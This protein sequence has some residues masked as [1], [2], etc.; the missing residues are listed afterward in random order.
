MKLEEIKGIGEN[1]LKL[2]NKLNIKTPEQLI[3]YYPYKYNII[4]NNQIN[5]L[6][7]KIDV[8]I[9]GIIITEPKTKKLNEKRNIMFFKIK[10]DNKI[11][12][13]IIF[14]RS[15]YKNKLNIGKTIIIIGKF[16]EKSNKIIAK[17]IRFE[18]FK[19]SE[20]IEPIYHTT[21]GI[22]GNQINKIVCNY[23]SEKKHIKDYIPEY[24][25]KKYNF[26][27]K[28]ESIVNI[29]NP[30]NIDTL[31]KAI[32]R[33]KYEELFIFLLKLSYL[34]TKNKI[35]GIK[36]QINYE[37]VR[38]F[39][40]NLPFTLTKDQV[41]CIIEIYND[42]IDEKQMNRLLQGD[43]GSGK[44][45]VAFT[46]LYMNY[47]SGYQGCLMAPTELLAQQH[48]NNI[49]K[50][51]EK[52]IN[53]ELLT[54]KTKLK[55]KKMIKQK[56]KDNKIDIIIGTH[57]LISEDVIFNNLGLVITDEQ[58]RFGVKQRSNLKN[59][60]KTPDILYMSATPIPRTYALT[61]Y[62]DMEISNIK[63]KPKGRKEV[64]TLL[65]KTNEI[66]DV[67]ELMNNELN[68]NHQIYVV[69]PL[70]EDNEYS[71]LQNIYSLAKKIE[72]LFKGKYKVGILHGKMKNEEKDNIM[73]NFEKNILKILV[74]TTV[75]EVGID[76]E[77][78]T[79]IV[80][81]DS[82][83]FGLSELHQL[84]GRVGR[85]EK[86]SYCVL[87]SD[88]ETERLK[89]LTNESDGFKIS[90]EDFKLRGSGDIFGIRQSGEINFVLTNIK[91]EYQ[92]LKK[93]KIDS[94]IFMK[95]YINNYKYKHIKEILINS[96][97]L[98]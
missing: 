28:E 39:I 56:L 79:M 12:N 84:R 35:K 10:L 71:N 41:K 94:D 57:A 27:S 60:G 67:I 9:E 1:K 45:I 80:I 50:I 21:K 24:L 8:V 23:L 22:T 59:K 97:N 49:K 37:I 66:K 65:K 78:A 29:H 54:G 2:L 92:L 93:I 95:K 69:A 86:E 87:I 44:T 81:F 62:G 46:A 30:K 26:I 25:V 11:I 18:K 19:L 83:R 4:K 52:N 68:N 3:N 73:K 47:I 77:N 5:C 14:N 13:V 91:D 36:K 58:H 53:I 88:N 48:Y 17:E 20:T 38:I 15:F 33:L 16:Y 98:D 43:V 72:K 34:K 51:L 76:V 85:N 82:Y 63:T 61:L 6:I 89:I 55:E 42:F 90:E 7:N 75:I 40:N 96:S 74:S 31:N 70:V 32:L 64:I